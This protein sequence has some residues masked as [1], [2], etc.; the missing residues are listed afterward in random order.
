MHN[1][2]RLG[3]INRFKFIPFRFPSLQHHNLPLA[4]V[5]SFH[6]LE[7]LGY[8]PV[9]LCADD[10]ADENRGCFWIAWFVHC[11]LIRGHDVDIISVDCKDS[12]MTT[13]NRLTTPYDI[14]LSFRLL[15]KAECTW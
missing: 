3:R 1:L 8:L 10:G 14:F 9:L 2:K 7:I 15:L 12:L 5:H 6:Y 11:F 4:F 13:K